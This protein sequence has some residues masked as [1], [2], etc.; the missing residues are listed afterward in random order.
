MATLNVL[1]TGFGVVR[2]GT[3]SDYVVFYGT[4]QQGN[5]NSWTVYRSFDVFQRLGQQLSMIFGQ[6]VPSCPARMFNLRFPDSLEK[7]RVELNM[8][9]MQLL[10]HPPI[11]QSHVFVDFVS[12]DANVPPLGLQNT[13]VAAPPRGGNI[14]DLDMDEMFDSTTDDDPRSHDELH[15]DDIFQFDY[16]TDMSSAGLDQQTLLKETQLQHAQHVEEQK[17]SEK[18]TLEDFVMI[19]VIGKGSFGKV[20]LVRKRDTGL[21]YAMKVLRKENIIKRNQ[22]EHTRTE[23]HVLGYV[24]HPFIVGLNY[25]F[26]TSEKLYF[27]LDYCA[28]GELFFHLGKVQRFPEHRARFYAAEITLAIEYV[29]NL[30][31]IYRDLKPENVLLDE[32]G[33]IRLTDF[34]LSKEGIQDDFSGA[35]SFCGTPEYLSPEILNRSGHG[36]AVDWW[37]L[38]ALLYEMLT[39]LPPFY[40]R[41]RDRLFEKI[42][43]GDLSFPKYLSPSAKDLLKKL[44]ERDPTRRLGTGPTD[45]SEIKNHPFFVEIKWDA[46]ATG[47]VPPPWRPTFSGALDTSQFDREFTDMPVVSPDNHVRGGMA[48][49][50]G[51]RPANGTAYGSSLA[52]NDPFKGFTYTEDSYLQDGLPGRSPATRGSGRMRHHNM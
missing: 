41:D 51:R 10:Q 38:G 9:M 39:G 1:L 23:R 40:C 7:T 27:V 18:V 12:A 45:A 43:K 30:D 25:A 36:R 4:I 52:S 16:N 15:D 11:Y 46:L 14:G 48:M 50:V 21:I 3:Q 29:H 6:A 28:G 32:N 26:Q 31:V 22:V 34:G 19:K 37:S 49:A 2:D 20:L 24:R 13:A 33:H 5:G 17:K 8:W 35:N 42:R 47:Q 44:L